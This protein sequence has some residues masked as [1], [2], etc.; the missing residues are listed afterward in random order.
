VVRN[1]REHKLQALVYNILPP[2]I[3]L[4]N[5]AKGLQNNSNN[6]KLSAD[7]QFILVGDQ[8]AVSMEPH[9]QLIISGRFS[10]NR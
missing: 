1:T 9:R 2:T 5:Y 7:G 10:Y 4:I 6:N 3:A 8:M